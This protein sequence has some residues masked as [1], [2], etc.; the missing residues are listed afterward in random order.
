MG[1]LFA[2]AL[3]MF[4]LCG[5]G[6]YLL[7]KVC[8][9]MIF[10]NFVSI[11][12][13]FIVLNGEY[14]RC[15]CFNIFLR[16]DVFVYGRQCAGVVHYILSFELLRHGY[17]TLLDTRCVGMLIIAKLIIKMFCSF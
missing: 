1:I 5:I 17:C 9:L 10:V 6:I 7:R 12:G 15:D 4:V 13:N 14:F 16:V 8:D 3:P 11:T 2:S